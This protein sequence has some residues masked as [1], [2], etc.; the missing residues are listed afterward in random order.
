MTK[1]NQCGMTLENNEYH[2]FAACLMFRSCRDSVTVRTNL[3]AVQTHSVE[4][5]TQNNKPEK[6]NKLLQP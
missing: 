4:L 5:A 1:C 6:A 2:P 3:S